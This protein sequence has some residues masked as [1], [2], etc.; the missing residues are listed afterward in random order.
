MVASVAANILRSGIG[1]ATGL[2]VARWLGPS[3]Y[4]RMA[5]LLAS[6]AAFRQ[7][8]DMGSASA[9]YTLLSQRPRSRQFVTYYWRWVAAQFLVCLIFLGFVLPEIW[10]KDLWAGEERGLIILAFIATFIQGTV[11]QITSQM[12][13]A[14]RGTVRVQ[15][16]NVLVSV[17]HLAVVLLLWRLEQLAIPFLVAS[18]A[19]EWGLAAMLAAK[20]YWA[21]V[22]DA[23]TATDTATSVWREFWLYCLPFIPYALLGFAHDFADRWMLQHWGGAQE[24]AY[25]SVAAQ[26]SAIAL[27]ATASILRVFWKEIAEAHHRNE[28]DRLERLYLQIARSLYFV[29][30]VMAGVAMPWAS[31][32]LQ[33]TVGAAYISGTMTLTLMFLY[34]VHQSMGQ[35]GGTMLLATGH[36]RIYVITGMGYLMSSLISAYFVMAPASAFVPGFELASQG[37]VMKMLLLQFVQVNIIAWIIARIF[38]WRFDWLYQLIGLSAC[39]AFGWTSKYLSGLIFIDTTLI[40]PMAASLIIYMILIGL[41]VYVIPS[42]AGFT[43]LRF[44]LKL[45][46]DSNSMR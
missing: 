13:E 16:L 31:E 34:P 21:N 8:L 6:F 27:L 40:L 11:W 25:Y 46:S 4:G 36:T 10:L 26:F 43:R 38:R 15:G 23:Q 7:L 39:I 20:I 3:D 22:P 14:Q 29:G 35:I 24:Q 37:M 2:L 32:I 45:T 42:V 33:L 44:S 19:L 9:F 5:F 41:L 17:V 1:F 28:L 12:V 30:A 18:V